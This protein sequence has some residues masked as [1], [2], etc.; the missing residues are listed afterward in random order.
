MACETNGSATVTYRVYTDGLRGP[1]GEVGPAGAPGEKGARGSQ[2]RRGRR[3]IR[4]VDGIP[5]VRESFW[6]FHCSCDE[7]Y[8]QYL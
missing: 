5:G 4:G 7:Q 3:G 1:V 6:H 2:G 8:L